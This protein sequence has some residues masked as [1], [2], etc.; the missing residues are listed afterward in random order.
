[1]DRC[2]LLAISPQ[3]WVMM[4]IYTHIRMCICRVPGVRRISNDRG[5]QVKVV[6]GSGATVGGNAGGSRRS[7]KG[8]I[9]S[10]VPEQ[11]ADKISCR[12]HSKVHISGALQVDS[13]YGDPNQ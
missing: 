6:L 7:K 10:Q 9:D 8:H 5:R 1:M 12:V 2:Q 13:L 11:G 3:L 4:N